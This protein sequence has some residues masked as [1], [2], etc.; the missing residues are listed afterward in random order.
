MCRAFITKPTDSKNNYT[1]MIVLRCRHTH[2]T[3]VKSVIDLDPDDLDDLDNNGATG[4]CVFA[5]DQLCAL[6]VSTTCLN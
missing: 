4:L 1:V 3:T 5:A 2:T 6:L